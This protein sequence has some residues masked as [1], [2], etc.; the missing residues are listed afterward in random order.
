[1]FRALLPS[2]NTFLKSILL[3]VAS[4]TSVIARVGDSLFCVDGEHLVGDEFSIS[5]ILDGSEA[6]ED[7]GDHFVMI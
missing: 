6:P 4:R 2:T 3:M 1:M 5:S 7:S